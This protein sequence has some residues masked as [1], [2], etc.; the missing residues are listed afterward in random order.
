MIDSLYLHIRECPLTRF[1][2]SVEEEIS[3]TPTKLSV[4]F[5]ILIELLDK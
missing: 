2:Y 5:W 1:F 4:F 3:W